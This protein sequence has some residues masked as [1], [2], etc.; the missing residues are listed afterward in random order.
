MKRSKSSRVGLLH[1]CMPNG[2]YYSGL[3]LQGLVLF[4]LLFFF[5]PFFSSFF[6]VVGGSLALE[7]C[8]RGNMR[9]AVGRFHT[10]CL[11]GYKG[12]YSCTL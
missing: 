7:A 9:Q 10:N 11:N 1:V 2:V 3:C 4:F 6:S 12:T 8:S 5:F